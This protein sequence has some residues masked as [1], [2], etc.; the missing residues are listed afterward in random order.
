M[1]PT[2]SDDIKQRLGVGREGVQRWLSGKVDLPEIR[3]RCTRLAQTLKSVV[4][5]RESHRDQ[6]IS[7][8]DV[9]ARAKIP[10]GWVYNAVT[11]RLLGAVFPDHRWDA[12]ID[13]KS[14]RMIRVS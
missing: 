12:E 14:A 11:A 3:D 10:H 2:S 13:P 5:G 8:S 9:A 6:F 1:T 7:I 4:K